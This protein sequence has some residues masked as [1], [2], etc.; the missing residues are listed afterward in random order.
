MGQCNCRKKRKVLER[1]RGTGRAGKPW[2]TGGDPMC[3][4]FLRAWGA[5]EQY[6]RAEGHSQDEFGVWRC[7]PGLGH[8]VPG[9]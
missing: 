3:P 6:G 7:C 9:A 1:R 5:S 8:L 4:P 2:G